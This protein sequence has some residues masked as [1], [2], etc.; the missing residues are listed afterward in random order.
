MGRRPKGGHWTFVQ[1]SGFSASGNGHAFRGAT[2]R[3]AMPARH[4]C[5]ECGLLMDDAS[6]NLIPR[7]HSMNDLVWML[8]A[9]PREMFCLVRRGNGA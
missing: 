1:A 7:Y 5:V 3:G 9:E 6:R 4:R 8:E 2:F